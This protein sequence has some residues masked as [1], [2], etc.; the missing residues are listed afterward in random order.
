MDFE[1]RIITSR[2]LLWRGYPE[3]MDVRLAFASPDQSA[4][5]QAD[6]NGLSGAATVEASVT[7]G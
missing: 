2:P 4:D 6:L 7:S 5:L 3:R 1:H